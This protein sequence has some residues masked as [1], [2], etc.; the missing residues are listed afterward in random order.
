VLVYPPGPLHEYVTPVV[1]VFEVKLRVAPAHNG[2]LLE[3][4]GVAGADGFVRVNGPTE[5]DL[6]PFCVT[7]ILSYTPADKLL[8]V[9][10]PVELDVIVTVVGV[11]LFFVY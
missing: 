5:F 1:L 3:A 6:Q 8:I 4:V 10:V 11:P 7:V 2:L 9:I